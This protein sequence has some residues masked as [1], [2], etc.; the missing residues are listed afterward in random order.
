MKIITSDLLLVI[1]SFYFKF[2]INGNTY[3]TKSYLLCN[4][5]LQPMMEQMRRLLKGD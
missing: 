4:F 3:Y 5:Y 1:N 2:D